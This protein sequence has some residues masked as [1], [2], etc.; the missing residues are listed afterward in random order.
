MPKATGTPTEFKSLP[1]YPE[2]KTSE[3]EDLGIVEHL[4][5][6]F[7]ILDM[8]RDICHP[9]SF[10][11]TISER[12]GRIRVV[13]T[14]V[15]STIMGALGVPLKIW[16]VSRADLPREVQEKYPEA[17]GGVKARTQFLMD[18]PEGKGAYLRI[19]AG[20]VSEFSF[21]YDTLDED[22]TKDDDGKVIRNLRTIRLW[23]YGPVL[24]GMNPATDVTDVK[25]PDSESESE[26]KIWVRQY[27]LQ[28]SLNYTQIVK[29]VSAAFAQAYNNNS[30]FSPVYW[31]K[32][33]F[34]K[35]IVVEDYDQSDL[36]YQ[37][38]YTYEEELISFTPQAEW[39]LG[40]YVFIPNSK[41]DPEEDDEDEED[42]EDEDSTK[43]LKLQIEMEQ[44]G[45]LLEEKAEAD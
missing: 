13:D 31:V 14:H 25:I 45:I 40:K 44:I 26:A 35:Y 21:G 27:G 1:A 23:E 24:F 41:E 30:E 8:G 34:D 17:T 18:T 42:E 16:E 19:K 39:V 2:F 7:G 22:L 11:K 36:A 9:G 3:D 32:E 6:V 10:T 29:D 37:V 33:V 28:K 5:S 12:S 38:G 20:A 43:A 15:R 4:I